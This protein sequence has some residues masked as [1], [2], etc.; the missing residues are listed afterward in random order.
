MTS[1]RSLAELSGRILLMAL[2]LISGVGK[3]TA[4]AATAGYMAA[5]G[6]P[7]A[8]LPLVI[9]VEIFGALAIILGWR[10]RL[11]ALL[12]L[13][14]TLATAML[15]HTNFADQ[16]ET[17]MFLKNLSIAGALLMLAVNGPGPLSLDARK[18]HR[19]RDAIATAPS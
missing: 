4:Y 15:F 18:A 16:I 14:Y 12:M 3:I 1:L 8:L 13:A 19:R 6:V 7:G 11:V 5:A 10:T 2:F 17:V 9:V